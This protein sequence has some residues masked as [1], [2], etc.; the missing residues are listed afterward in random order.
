MRKPQRWLTGLLLCTLAAGFAANAAAA[1]HATRHAQAAAVAAADQIAYE[2]LHG[3]LGDRI[4]VHTTYGTTRT[5]VLQK[6]SNSEITLTLA[7]PGG[8]AE[9]TIPK[10]TIADMVAVPAPKR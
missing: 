7:T 3:Y 4:T 2:N 5:G 9:L 10:N 6:F 8:P 1:P